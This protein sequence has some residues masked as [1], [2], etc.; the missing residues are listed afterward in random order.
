MIRCVHV[1]N[2]AI[3]K[4]AT[5]DLGPGLNLLTGETGAG[6][7]ILVDA[8][9][10]GLGARADGD[11]VRTGTEKCSVEIEFDL[12]GHDAALS[13][14]ADR[15]YEADGASIV[16]HREVAEKGRSRAFLGGVLAPIADVRGFAALVAAIHGQ[17]QHHLLLD[18]A[19]HRDLLDRH[20][21]ADAE[22]RAMEAEASELTA[23]TARL[24][25]LRDGAQRIAQRID[26]LGY[27]VREIDG[28]QVQPGERET[29]RAERDMRR[30]S[31]TLLRDC[32][33][34]VEALY[35]GESAALARLVEGIRAARE[36]VRFD[37]GLGEDLQRVESAKAEIEE[38]VLRLRGFADKLDPDPQRLEALEERIQGIEALLRKY[39]PGGDEAALLAHREAAAA[40]L[41]QLTDGS[42]T[43]AD[44]DARVEALRE[45]ARA[46]AVAL[47]RKRRAAAATLEKRL[48][49][50]LRPL[51]M[52]ETRFAVEFRLRP[53]AGSGIWIEGEEVSVDAGGCDVVEFLLSANR[54]EAMRPLHAV[55]SGG[56]LSRLMLAL[57]VVLLGHDAP[58]SLV[59]DEVDAGIGGATAEVVGRKLKAL[60]QGHQ[61]ICVTH[62]APIAALA[63]RHVRVAKRALR[64]R[65]EVAVEVLEGE[66]RVRELGRMLAGETI[67]P[68]ALRHAAEM[69]AR[70]GT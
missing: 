58:R 7:S 32:R 2:L 16:V 43:V 57:E 21:G 13:F 40:E 24:V 39:A 12:A 4:D 20:A 6:K 65:T 36:V 59:F 27:Q 45:R 41:R 52:P 34:A 10:L 38:L 50:E 22:R 29:L 55:A 66:E 56:E 23:A 18:P 67:T 62:L 9:L 19:R 14:L 63:D 53:S 35:D 44:L 1:R 28:I 3:I 30:H 47:S 54:G 70:A 26:M 37:P 42:D 60:A 61:V 64:G 51:A 31:E 25:S 15:G 33:T 8:L 11:L 48:E 49:A 5:L 46:A 69:L 68:Q 17:H